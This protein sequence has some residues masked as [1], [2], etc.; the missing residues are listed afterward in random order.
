MLTH[1]HHRHLLLYSH[2]TSRIYP[3]LCRRKSNQPITAPGGR[4]CFSTFDSRGLDMTSPAALSSSRNAQRCSESKTAASPSQSLQKTSHLLQALV[5]RF[6]AI[7]LYL[8]GLP[9]C[10]RDPL[11]DSFASCTFPVAIYYPRTS[12]QFLA[13]NL[14]S[15][16]VRWGHILFSAGERHRKP[17]VRTFP[18]IT[19]Y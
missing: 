15:S 18:H 10:M 2:V 9:T 4:V 14:L 3:S 8:Q 1:F 19:C 5:Q 13:V 17:R 7:Q 16:A 12:S 6:N 11:F